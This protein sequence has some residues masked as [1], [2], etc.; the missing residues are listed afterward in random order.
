[1]FARKLRVEIEEAGGQRPCPVDWLDRFF[2][3]NFTGLRALDSTLPVS[4]GCMEA[5]F[6]V[7]LQIL[8]QELER[9]LRGH[10]LLAPEARLRIATEP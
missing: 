10:K 1:M 2:M 8:R 7:D 6:D 9:W 3:R 4:D 5:G